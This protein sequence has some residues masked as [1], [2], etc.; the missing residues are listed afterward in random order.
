MP[1]SWPVDTDMNRGFNIPKASPESAAQ[2][3]FSGLENG[4]E[5]IFPDPRRSPSPR[6]GALAQS[7]RSNGSS[8]L[9]C[10]RA[11]RIWDDVA[12]A[13]AGSKGEGMKE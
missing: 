8:R 13:A 6:A 4:E 11:R 2:G 3:I 5:E 7:R 1:S 12:N 9:S 10:R